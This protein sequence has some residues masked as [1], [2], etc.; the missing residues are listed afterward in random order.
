M[1]QENSYLVQLKI[2]PSHPEG[3][4]GFR[5]QEIHRLHFPTLDEAF[6]KLNNLPKEYFHLEQ[7]KKHGLPGLI[8]H[9]SIIRA[10]TEEPLVGLLN[11]FKPTDLSLK[12]FV[13]SPGP[14]LY[15]MNEK[16][17]GELSRSLQQD[18]AI[19][20]S[21]TT[22]HYIPKNVVT[23]APIMETQLGSKTTPDKLYDLPGYLFAVDTTKKVYGKD[24]PANEKTGITIRDIIPANDLR[25]AVTTFMHFDLNTVDPLLAHNNGKN[26]CQ[27]SSSIKTLEDNADIVKLANVRYEGVRP[28]MNEAGLYIVYASRLHRALAE[29]AAPELKRLGIPPDSLSGR[30]AAYKIDPSMRAEATYEFQQLKA[31]IA[32][33]RNMAEPIRQR[34][35]RLLLEQQTNRQRPGL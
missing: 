14:V 18:L 6:H 5:A 26:I 32:P 8:Q 28:D 24:I 29:I 2:L 21:L 27:V 12:K 20:S 3:A 9:A 1:Q 33:E 23:R 11:F 10:H 22:D 7:V 19:H 35:A 34:P 16:I 13:N 15:F 17:I 30:L 31:S 4:P 25:T